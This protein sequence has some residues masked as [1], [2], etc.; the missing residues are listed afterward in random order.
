M[1]NEPAK[2]GT[3]KDAKRLVELREIMGMTQR[4][5]AREWYVSAGAIALWEKGER[6]ISGPVLKLIE[7]Y[8][9]EFFLNKEKVKGQNYS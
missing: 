6:P 9:K 5:L 7:I 4:D 2:K 1:A 8:Q 3:K